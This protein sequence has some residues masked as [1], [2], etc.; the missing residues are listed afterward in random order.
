M[1]RY[2]NTKAVMRRF[3]NEIRHPATL[4]GSQP[5][6]DREGCRVCHATNLRFLDH[7]ANPM[8]ARYQVA[9]RATLFCSPDNTTRS[10]INPRLPTGQLG[11][12]EARVFGSAM[13]AGRVG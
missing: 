9:R 7:S 5:P 1:G 2:E 8:A 12:G 6:F 10:S 4:L 11:D 3:L 13:C